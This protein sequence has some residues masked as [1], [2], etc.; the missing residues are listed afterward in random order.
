[1]ARRVPPPVA[2]TDYLGSISNAPT[3][4]A[5]SP[6]PPPAPA[7]LQ[8]PRAPEGLVAANA[9]QPSRFAP[10]ARGALLAG[11]A[12]VILA[13]AALA[14]L[15][16]AAALET[17][18]GRE[19]PP[20]V[21]RRAREGVSHARARRVP[22]PGVWGLALLAGTVVGS[23][24][25]KR[26]TRRGATPRASTEVQPLDDAAHLGA[27]SITGAVR[28]T[29]QDRVLVEHLDGVDVLVVA[30][31]LG[32]LPRGGEAAHEA[33]R[34][35]LERLRSELPKSATCPEGIRTLLLGVLW[36]SASHLAR[37]AHAQGWGD[38]S[39]GFRTTLILVA[40]T[41][42]LYVTAWVGDGGVFVCRD[43]ALLALLEPHK[44]PESP[45]VLDA[46][47]GPRSDGR[48]SWAM[49]RRL[50]GD[51][52]VAATDGVADLFDAELLTSVRGCLTACD[53]DA[54]RAAEVLVEN[55]ANARDTLGPRFT[56][57]LTVALLTSRRES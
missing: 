26:R 53:G 33:S 45:D 37:H 24:G 54:A 13:L 31:G 38:P 44:S 17:L 5:G 11:A 10:R 19:V 42:T 25:S 22:S 35:A 20:A 8:A 39:D 48:P 36:E 41:P 29:N 32:G 51:L 1:M 56:D 52:L 3:P 9:V 18:P 12:S 46:S 14:A 27:C 34:F 15:G 50:P 6:T 55:L 4:P 40:A 16:L 43:D 57:N 23:K 28:E 7:L 47:L 49:T 30:D 2:L 21:E